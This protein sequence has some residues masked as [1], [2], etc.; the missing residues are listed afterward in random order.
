MKTRSSTQSE[1]LE[2]L[3][4]ADP[5]QFTDNFEE[6]S[7]PPNQNIPPK[8]RILKPFYYLKLVGNS[9][10]NGENISERLYIPRNVWVQ[11]CKEISLITK[12]VQ[13]FK[14]LSEYLQK[15]GILIQKNVIH[16]TVNYIQT[17]SKLMRWLIC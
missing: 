4:I 12:K 1:E 10:R 2:Q 9:I 17:N 13:I 6:H 3:N 8:E 15:Y 16:S 11:D 7:I 5:Y 14:F